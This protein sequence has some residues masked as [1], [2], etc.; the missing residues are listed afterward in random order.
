MHKKGFNVGEVMGKSFST[1]T[2]LLHSCYQTEVSKMA[3][4]VKAL[5]TELSTGS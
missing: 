5:T 3:H 2:G 1:C 4:W